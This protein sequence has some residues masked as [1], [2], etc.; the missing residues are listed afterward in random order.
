MYVCIYVCMYVC[1]WLCMDVRMYFAV[2]QHDSPVTETFLATKNPLDIKHQSTTFLKIN[3][4]RLS[5]PNRE[6][7]I[8]IAE[9]QA[10]MVSLTQP[11]QKGIRKFRS[12]RESGVATTL[13]GHVCNVPDL[14]GLESGDGSA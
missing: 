1:V 3:V 7:D 10:K 11:G 12:I 4:A 13:T 6:N 14:V 8:E 2:D 9:L 5:D